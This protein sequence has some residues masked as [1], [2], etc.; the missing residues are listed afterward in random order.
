M[1]KSLLLVALMMASFVMQAQVR[2]PAASPAGSVTATVGLTDIKISYFRP[3]AKGRTIFSNNATTLVPYGKIWRTGANGGTKI[4]FSEDV[5][6]EGIA[7]P[8]GE[9]ILLSWPGEK[10][11]TLALN[12]NVEMGGDMKKYDAAQDV[13][14]FKVKPGKLANKIETLT[15]NVGDIAADNKSAKVELAWENTSVKFTVAADFDAAVIASIDA[16]TKAEKVA[17]YDYFQAAV[18]YL[19]TGRDLKQALAWVNKAAEGMNNPFWVLHQKAK[20]EKGLGDKKAALAT[21]TASLE[22]AKVAE[23][24]DYQMM[25]ETLIKSLK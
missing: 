20:I 1:K 2:T 23:N 10:E 19:E 9:Y 24:R 5:K 3:S 8:K 22:A 6:V 11:W 16:T 7:V 15:F 25:N 18:Y 4:S 12:K 17:P 14:N 13:A 21:A